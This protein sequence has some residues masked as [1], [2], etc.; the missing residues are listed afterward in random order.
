[1]SSDL[2]ESAPLW[3]AVGNLRDAID[4]TELPLDL[5]ET[6]DGQAEREDRED[7]RD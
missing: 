7:D 4:A 2:D 1:M 3:G 6:A 5:P